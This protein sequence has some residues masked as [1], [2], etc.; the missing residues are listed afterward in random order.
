VGPRRQYGWLVGASVLAGIA[1]T[2]RALAEPARAREPRASQHL[3]GLPGVDIGGWSVRLVRMER[4]PP[5]YDQYTFV[6]HVENEQNGERQ[7]LQLSNETV[8]LDSLEVVGDLLVVFGD[9]GTSADVVTVFD[10]KRGRS[11]GSFLCWW[12]QLSATGRYIIAVQ[13]YPRMSDPG[14]TSNVVV[15]YDLKGLESGPKVTDQGD[16]GLRAIYPPES[17]GTGSSAGSWVPEAAKRHN[18]D[19]VGFLWDS[20]DRRVVFVDRT[21]S[22]TFLVAVDLAEQPLSHRYPL[23][24]APL[25]SLSKDA[26]QYAEVLKEEQAHLAVRSL[27]WLGDERYVGIE[28]NLQFSANANAYRQAVQPLLKVDLDAG[29]ENAVQQRSEPFGSGISKEPSGG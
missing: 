10:M 29:R 8:N 11:V 12:P 17:V 21:E 4:T 26:P 9:A 18:I 24:V 16:A 6:F 13:F 2:G 23:D 15:V 25:L 1:C 7:D 27:R 20:R 28:L 3:A 5:N 19:P 22:K 14:A